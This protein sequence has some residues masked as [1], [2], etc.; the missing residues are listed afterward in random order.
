MSTNTFVRWYERNVIKYGMEVFEL[1]DMVTGNTYIFMSELGRDL[2]KQQIEQ[3][4]R[5][6]GVR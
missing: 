5:M 2:K 4:E 3:K 1:V 6:Q